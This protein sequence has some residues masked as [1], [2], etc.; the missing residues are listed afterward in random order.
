MI[1]QR[2]LEYYMHPQHIK[3]ALKDDLLHSC[4]N[5]IH[6]ATELVKAWIHEPETTQYVYEIKQSIKHYPLYDIVTDI[7]TTVCMHATTP[8]PLVSIA[9]MISIDGLSK[10]H[11]IQT[12]CGMLVAISKIPFFT[13]IDNGKGNARSIKS[14]MVLDQRIQDRLR[15]ACYLPPMVEKPKHIKDNNT[16]GYLT[17]NDSVILGFKE[18]QHNNPLALDVINTLNNTQYELSDYTLDNFTKPWHRDELDTDELALLSADEQNGYFKEASTFAQYQEQ[19]NVM[20]GHLKDQ[21]VY[22]THK[23]DK[24][25]RVYS[26]GYHYNPQ[27]TSFFKA[28]LN[29]KAKETVTGE[30]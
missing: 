18:N 22:F 8:I 26:Q 29:L 6:Q 14:N 21:T 30:L 11:S 5:E 3:Q 7:I 25:G 15:L 4:P 28:C 20:T 10:R 19:F 24:R 2:T 12:V 9:S 23:Y 16:S 17:F 1:D 27:G 13:I